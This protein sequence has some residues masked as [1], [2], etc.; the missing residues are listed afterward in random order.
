MTGREE[1]ELYGRSRSWIGD[2]SFKMFVARKYLV[3]PSSIWIS[4]DG[5]LENKDR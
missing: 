3:F 5:G 1:G 4:Q 2:K